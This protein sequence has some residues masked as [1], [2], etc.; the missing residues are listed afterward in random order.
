MSIV[1]VNFTDDI[2]VIYAEKGTMRQDYETLIVGYISG[3][4]IETLI[5]ERAVWY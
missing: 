4:Y 1:Y 2:F 5:E 3:E